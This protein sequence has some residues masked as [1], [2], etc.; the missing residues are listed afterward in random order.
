MIRDNLF[1]T[2][3]QIP[4]EDDARAI[5]RVCEFGGESLTNLVG[6]AFSDI[7]QL[8]VALAEAGYSLADKI[9]LGKGRVKTHKGVA[10]GRDGTEYT[11]IMTEITP[12]HL[13]IDNVEMTKVGENVDPEGLKLVKELED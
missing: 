9:L 1:V 3:A 10:I 11:V 5:E 13:R 12:N 2:T 8:R 6:L 7:R 4:P